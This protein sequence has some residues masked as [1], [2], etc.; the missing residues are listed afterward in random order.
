MKQSYNKGGIRMKLPIKILSTAF[1]SML[2]VTACSNEEGKELKPEPEPKPV[3]E[4]KTVTH[5]GYE[6]NKEQIDV[7]KKAIDKYQD[8]KV[9]DKDGFIPVSVH[10]PMM[11][12][13]FVNPSITEFEPDK[14][15]TLLY[16]YENDK[17]VLVAAEWGTTD[18]ENTPSPVNGVEWEMVHEASAHYDDLS[19]LAA[20]TPEDV[21]QVNPETGAKFTE[22]HPDFW[23][24][25]VYTHIENPEG[26][27]A[28]SNPNVTSVDAPMIPPG[29]EKYFT[30]HEH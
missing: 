8:I 23:G 27:F 16:T 21:L 2:L 30:T 29:Y 12:Y 20:P 5:P 9:A 17:F 13:H 7:L 6:E 15:S 11:G 19:E 22:W 14:P 4:V 3:E 18:P 26:P 25:H 10:V 28:A 24:I 1:L